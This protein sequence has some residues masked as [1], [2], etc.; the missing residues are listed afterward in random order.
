MYLKYTCGLLQPRNTSILYWRI[1]VDARLALCN[2]IRYVLVQDFPDLNHSTDF[3]GFFIG[4]MMKTK[5]VT[6]PNSFLQ[7]ALAYLCHFKDLML[8]VYI[9]ES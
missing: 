8:T 9:Y 5:R 6:K 7:Y 1:N 2:D 3:F 4:H